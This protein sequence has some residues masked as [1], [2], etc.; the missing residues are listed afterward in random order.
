MLIFDFF[1]WTQYS[2]NYESFGIS[3]LPDS[4]LSSWRGASKNPLI[5]VTVTKY[6]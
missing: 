6:F 1:K 2:T 3:G 5:V 4:K